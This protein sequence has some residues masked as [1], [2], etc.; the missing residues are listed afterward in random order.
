MFQVHVFIC[1]KINNSCLGEICQSQRKISSDF[2]NCIKIYFKYIYTKKKKTKLKKF[3]SVEFFVC[4]SFL[5][6]PLLLIFNTKLTMKRALICMF[7]KLFLVLF[8]LKVHTL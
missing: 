8:F 7:A 6:I 3:L 1:M 5:H 2:S 4:F